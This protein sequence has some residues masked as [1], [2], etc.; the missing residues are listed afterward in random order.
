MTINLKL[1][2]LPLQ[3]CLNGE[4]ISHLTDYELLAIIIGSGTKAR[5]VMELSRLI[6]SDMDGLRGIASSGIREIAEKPG[7][8]L[9]KAIRIH[10]AL[11]LGKRALTENGTMSHIDSPSAVW[12]LLLAD[13]MGLE[14]EKFMALV[15]NNKNRLIKKTVIS[16]GTV[17]EAIVHPREVFRNAI[18]ESGSAIIIAHNHPSGELKPSKEDIK[19]TKRLYEA[20]LLLGIP[21]LDHVIITNSAFLSMK[22]EGYLS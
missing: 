13:M 5:P 16:V 12:R 11:E 22:D 17:S 7:I 20:G 1:Q 14:K 18:K 15:L 10:S 19:T 8:G 2:Q 9:V 3:K 6:I 4:E 21:L